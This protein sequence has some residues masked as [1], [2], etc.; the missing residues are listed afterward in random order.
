MPTSRDITDE[1][2]G[3]KPQGKALDVHTWFA[4]EGTQVADMVASKAV[5]RGAYDLEL[6]GRT[7]AGFLDTEVP[8]GAGES[9]FYILVGILFYAEGKIAR[10]LSALKS[11]RLPHVDDWL[12]LSVYGRMARYVMEKGQWP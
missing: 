3:G 7:M 10:A 11:G 12:D 1:V 4:D 2:K 8:V 9:E 5:E 6:L